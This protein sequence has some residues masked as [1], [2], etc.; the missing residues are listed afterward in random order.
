M[1]VGSLSEFQKKM[2]HKTKI[3]YKFVSRNLIH[4]IFQ[5]DTTDW[6]ILFNENA[7]T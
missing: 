7:C 5:Y 3:R 4:T 6:I 2:F 1:R